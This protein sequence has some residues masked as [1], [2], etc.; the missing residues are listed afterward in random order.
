MKAISLCSIATFLL[1]LLLYALVFNLNPLNRIG[2]A[3]FIS[4]LPAILSL[5]IVRLYRFTTRGAVVTYVILL[6]TTITIQGWIRV[7]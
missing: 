6:L 1:V 5:I 7:P 3:V 2:Y 4:V